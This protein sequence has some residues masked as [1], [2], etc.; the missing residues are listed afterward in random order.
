[1]LNDC[2]GSLVGVGT[3]LSATRLGG[4]L[5]S[6]TFLETDLLL[7]GGVTLSVSDNLFEGNW[8]GWGL[9]V[10]MDNLDGFWDLLS[11]G[12]DTGSQTLRVEGVILAF[13]DTFSLD[14][15][16]LLFLIGVL[17]FDGLLSG[18]FL[19]FSGFDDEFLFS[20]PGSDL[21]GDENLFLLVVILTL[22]ITSL[23]WVGVATNTLLSNNGS[24]STGSLSSSTLLLELGG[25]QRA[26][27]GGVGGR[28]PGAVSETALSGVLVLA[29][30][31]ID[32]L[33]ISLNWLDTFG[34]NSGSESNDSFTESVDTDVV[35]NLS[36][37]LGSLA[38]LGTGLDD[39][40]DGDQNVSLS[41]L[42]SPFDDKSPVDLVSDSE[43]VLVGKN[44]SSNT[45]G[46]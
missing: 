29:Q 22:I 27:L 8:K 9:A 45:F 17:V 24:A 26:D 5:L 15:N 20:L 33:G 46:S 34:N 25:N 23:S 36:L 39:S 4:I 13:K 11:F 3:V 14:L 28:G 7:V 44:A 38:S 41:D 19:S 37:V 18:F 10:I 21:L 12:S 2:D 16:L 40:S 32:F 42:G 1:M 6:E 30:E 43:F 31:L 35:A